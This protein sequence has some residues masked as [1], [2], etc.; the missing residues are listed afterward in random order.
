[1]PRPAKEWR[2][3]PRLI[4]PCA[5]RLSFAFDG[6]D[7]VY[8][9]VAEIFAVE[10]ESLLKRTFHCPANGKPSSSSD[11][12]VGEV[13]DHYHVIAR[14]AQFPAAEGDQVA[15]VV[16]TV[17]MDVLACQPA[18]QWRLVRSLTRSRRRTMPR[19]SSLLSSPGDRIEPLALQEFCP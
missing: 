13:G 10:A 17:D 14:A 8:L 12:G 3:G 11:R 5:G 1:M 18:S 9:V 16:D 15:G 2:L 6:L 19:N 4:V 7:V